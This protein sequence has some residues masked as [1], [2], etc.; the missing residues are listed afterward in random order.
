MNLIVIKEM[1]SSMILHKKVIVYEGKRE[2]VTE[3]NINKD[4]AVNF[5]SNQKISEVQG[6]SKENGSENEIKI[7]EDLLIYRIINSF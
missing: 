4:G 1:N 5:F 3:H 6:N 7:K 2:I